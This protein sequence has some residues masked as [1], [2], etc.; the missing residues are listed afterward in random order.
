MPGLPF[1]GEPMG[2]AIARRPGRVQYAAIGGRGLPG[3]AKLRIVGANLRER[4]VAVERRHWLRGAGAAL[5]APALLRFGPA[6]GEP[7]QTLT[8]ADNLSPSHPVTVRARQA[9]AAIHAETAGQVTIKI[10]PSEQLAPN[11]DLLTQVRDG[12]ISLL[13]LSGL[14]LSRLVPAAAICGTGFAWLSYA[15]L[16]AAMDGPLGDVLRTEIAGQGL[17]AVARIWDSGFRHITSGLRP[18]A[19]P[20][21]LK[22]LKIR[23]PAHPLWTQLFRAF[24]SD[25]MVIKFAELHTALKAGTVQA[26]ESPLVTINAD[27]LYEVQTY[28]SLTG[29]M[30][31]GLWCLAN[32]RVWAAMPAEWQAIVSHHF[33]AAALGERADMQVLTAGLLKEFADRGLKINP[34]DPAD[35][36]QALQA[37]G[38]YREVRASFSDAVWAP[39]AALSGLEG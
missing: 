19:A 28:L 1:F 18:I 38:F 21:D 15:Q 29:H 35:F 39:F 14:N 11:S 5:A 3:S 12:T 6:R 30:W 20:A 23:V 25:P 37:S 7:G 31:D 16:W 32:G 24:G 27:R 9:I 33:D 2:Q 22:R 36:R 13:A 4:A 26:Q 17:V 10:L 8:Y 34:T